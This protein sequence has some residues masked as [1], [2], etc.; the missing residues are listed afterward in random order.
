M[1]IDS[2]DSI[3]ISKKKLLVSLG[4][5]NIVAVDSNDAI[6]ISSFDK[7]D[8]LK[9]IVSLLKSN[10]RKEAEFPVYVEEN[11]GSYEIISFSDK[12]V[13]KKFLLNS[14]F[15]IPSDLLSIVLKKCI[16][17]NGKIQIEIGGDSFEM[18]PFDVFEIP[19]NVSCK[20]TNNCDEIFEGIII[21]NSN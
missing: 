16:V 12:I 18:K 20:I 13:C 1:T 21:S 17:I 3:L 8:E 7:L 11:W 14:G 9:N 10:G 6:M 5:K 4:L 19:S 2:T 15:S